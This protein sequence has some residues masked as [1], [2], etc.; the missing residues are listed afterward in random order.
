MQIRADQR[1]SEEIRDQRRCDRLAAER[2]SGHCRCRL[3]SV[4]G[5][6]ELRAVSLPML[7]SLAAM[8]VIVT[9]ASVTL[10][11]SFQR[12][13]TVNDNRFEYYV[14]QMAFST[15]HTFLIV[16]PCTS[17]LEYRKFVRFINSWGTLQV[18]QLQYT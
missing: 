8:A 9:A 10:R 15:A 4:A 12:L 7:Y 6:L 11:Q 13:Y 2:H 1:R 17:M 16:L 3:L 14:T 18:M 5:G